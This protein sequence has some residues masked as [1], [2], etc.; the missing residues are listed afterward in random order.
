MA[1][2]ISFPEALVLNVLHSDGPLTME[3]LLGKLS[4]LSWNQVFCAVDALSRNG[5]LQLR[6]TNFDFELDLPILGVSP[7]ESIDY[8]AGEN[9]GKSAW[10]GSR[11]ACLG[12]NK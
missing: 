6:R 10:P 11:R 1:M 4:Q 3:E 5:K 2:K 12:K 8:A 7:G 9:P